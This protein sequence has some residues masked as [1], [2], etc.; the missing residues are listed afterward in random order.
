[1][2]ELHIARYGDDGQPVYED[3]N[4]RSVEEINRQETMEALDKSEIWAEFN[5]TFEPDDELLQAAVGQLL[6]K[7]PTLDQLENLLR[8]IIKAGGQLTLKDS[9]G[10]RSQFAFQRREEEPVVEEPEVPVDRNGKPLSPS[11]L[12][13]KEHHEWA[14]THS[15]ADCQKR[16]QADPSFRKFRE[17]S[18][19]LESNVGVPDAVT[20]LNTRASRKA[21]SPDLIAFADE[22]LRT[23]SSRVKV[24][25]SPAA[26]PNGYQQYLK[27]IEAATLAGLI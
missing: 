8:S 27:N 17:S 22:F 1:M 19:R 14:S 23:P 10:N 16:A 9:T 6:G 24:L 3:E 15:A 5:D 13:W 2:S 4:G 20:N 21:A 7:N 26:N 11:Q 12:A 18:L 25:R